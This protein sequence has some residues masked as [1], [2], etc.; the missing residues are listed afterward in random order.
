[1]GFAEAEGKESMQRAYRV[2]R[3]CDEKERARLGAP[4]YQH[5]GF[6]PVAREE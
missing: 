3:D 2:L 5:S 6:F 4:L 1:M